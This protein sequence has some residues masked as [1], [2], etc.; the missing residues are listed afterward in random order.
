MAQWSNVD[1]TSNSVL[2]G[3]SGYNLRANTINRDLFYD[4]VSRSAFI[5]DMIIGQF[6]VDTTEIG[7]AAGNVVHVTAVTNG[8]GYTAN[9]NT[10]I[11]GSGGS[12]ANVTAVAAS[13]KITSYTVVTRGGS[14]TSNPTV[15]VDA[16]VAT[17]FNAN[18]AVT[19]GPST[20]LVTDANSSITVSSAGSFATGDAIIYRVAAGNTAISGLT[21]GTTYYVQAA[22][23]TWLGLSATSGGSRITLT[24][25]VTETGHTLQGITATAAAVVGGGKNNGIAHAGWNVR[26]VGTGGRAGRVQYETLVAMGSMTGDGED[27]ILPDA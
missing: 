12:G 13:G 1:D 22:N 24:K 15:T 14:Y 17:S 16:P 21:S 7:V 27:V 2:W 6:G 3:V 8:T 9:A 23:S 20:G 11:T 5:T 4:N 26:K 25:G 18:T 19:A 10:T